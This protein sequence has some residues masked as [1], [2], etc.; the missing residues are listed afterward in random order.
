VLS[1]TTC[2]HAHMLSRTHA[3]THTCCHAHMLSRTPGLEKMSKY[4][5]KVG[6]GLS[7]DKMNSS[8]DRRWSQ[9]AGG[10]PDLAN[11][12]PSCKLA[13]ILQTSPTLQSCPS[14]NLVHGC[15]VLS[16]TCASTCAWGFVLMLLV[17]VC[18]CCLLCQIWLNRV[19]EHD[20]RRV[21]AFGRV[22][23]IWLT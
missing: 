5:G 23:Q 3:V 13:P 21:L 7:C 17:S 15:A 16:R 8:C 14:C 22:C 4:T 18:F 12:P 19:L 2:C 11:L 6:V 20:C 9:L 1:R 10:H